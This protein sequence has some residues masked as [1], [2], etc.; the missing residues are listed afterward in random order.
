MRAWWDE[1]GNYVIAGV[2]IGIVLLFGWSIAVTAHII[3]LALEV[4]RG[5]SVLV[6]MLYLLASIFLTNVVLARLG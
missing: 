4:S 2:V 6:V 5:R 3:R 1:Y